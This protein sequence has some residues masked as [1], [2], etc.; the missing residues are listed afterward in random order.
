M[1]STP[2]RL[3]RLLALFQ[4]RRNWSGP[5][6]A[7]RLEIT[8]RTLRRDIDRLRALGYEIDSASGVAGG[9]RLGAGAAMPPLMLEDD[10]AVAVALGLSTAS[11]AAVA[12][13][14]EAAL[15][16][17]AKLQ[18]VLPA[19][20]RRRLGAVQAAVVPLAMDGPSAAVPWKLISSIADSCAERREL[21]FAYRDRGQRE[22]TRQVE[23]HRLVHSGRY[24]YLLGWDTGR[25]DWRT[26]RVDRI[27]GPTARGALF[28]ARKLPAED[29]AAYVSRALTVAPYPCR[30]SVIVHAPAESLV[31]KTGWM[32]AVLEVIDARHTRVELGAGSYDGLAV[33]LACLG[34]DF[35]VLEPPELTAVLSSVSTR[36]QRAARLSR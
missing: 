5:E 33:W 34:H 31:D 30:A 14:D 18:Q 3:L 35:Q 23:P 12:D 27:N 25:R 20:L 17:L 28:A 10:E 4:A 13:L 26:F 21:R 9:Y 19:H 15:R 22:S 36:L 29:V 32:Q 2:E 16:A 11:A 24:W 1:L 7:S 8:S 6:L